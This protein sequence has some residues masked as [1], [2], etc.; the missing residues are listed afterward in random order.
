VNI[1]LLGISAHLV[2]GASGHFETFHKG[3]FTAMKKLIGESNCIFLGSQISKETDS[4][5]TAELPSSLASRVPWLPKYSLNSLVTTSDDASNNL[6]IY[7]YE[8]NLASL[9]LLG[10][11][12]R[13]RSDTF[14]Y[15]NLFDSNR[16]KSIF[17]SNLRLLMFKSLFLLAYRGLDRKV[18]LSA[19]TKRFA[20]LLTRK[21]GK[22]FSEY[23]MYSALDFQL[24]P[25]IQNKKILINFRGQQSEE[26]MKSAIE[27]L[28][29]LQGLELD[30]HGLHDKGIAQDLSRFPKITILPNQ[31]DESTYFS[32]Y[33]YYYRVAF[34]YD[35]DFFSM[36]SS[37]RLA[38]AIL[39]GA[40]LVVPRNTSLEDVLNESG[41]GN[42]FSFSSCESLA[43]AL[44]LD[45]TIPKRANY[46]PTS[47]RAAQIILNSMEELIKD[48]SDV[49]DQP[50][51]RAINNAFDDSIRGVL[52]T[53]RIVFGVGNRL[54]RFLKRMS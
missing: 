27:R 40:Q 32:M 51:R 22:K 54:R 43:S 23:P 48:R 46:L 1:K 45:P 9:F 4:W 12:V 10:S 21:L 25:D 8:G 15:F 35:P 31:V 47:S 18:H 13:Q 42:T 39:A 26:L 37:G 16:Y 24:S 41:N 11:V 19:D 44:I 17:R 29:A 28:P 2:S 14:L 6:V 3:L 34:I 36:Q 38:D 33:K 50:H 30:L 53:L 49:L 7:V 20:Q 52:W 5:F